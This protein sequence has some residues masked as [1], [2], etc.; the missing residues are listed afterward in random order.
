MLLPSGPHQ[1]MCCCCS[2]LED[3]KAGCYKKYDEK[4]HASAVLCLPDRNNLTHNF[5]NKSMIDC[6]SGV[7]IPSIL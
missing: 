1:H 7:R 6:R 5:W 2:S 3:Q 4:K